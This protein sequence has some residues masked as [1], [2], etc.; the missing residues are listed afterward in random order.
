VVTPDTLFAADTRIP[1]AL[2]A[3]CY[4]ARAVDDTCEL[5][6]IGAGAAADK[7]LISAV[8]RDQERIDLGDADGLAIGD[9]L[10]IG[11]AG[12]TEFIEIAAIEEVADVSNINHANSYAAITLAHAAMS[13]HPAGAVVRQRSV[14]VAGPPRLIKLAATRGDA[15]LLMEEVGGWSA[16]DV[17]RISGASSADEYHRIDFYRT[18]ADGDGYY[19]LPAFNRLGQ[20]SISATQGVLTGSAHRIIP[21]Y[22]RHQFLV[23]IGVAGP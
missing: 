9:L 10:E 4:A 2:T 16:N 19:R 20:M 21:D 7:T 22:A 17:I 23:D 12:D 1:V 6:G 3:P 18:I 8:G 11:A 15:C 14:A 13:R 5:V